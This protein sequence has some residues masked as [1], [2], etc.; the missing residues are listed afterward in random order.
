MQS[1]LD[2]LLRQVAAKAALS[3]DL[4]P[5]RQLLGMAEAPINGRPYGRRLLDAGQRGEVLLMSW[6]PGVRCAPHDH[7][8]AH[9]AMFVLRGSLVERDYDYHGELRLRGQRDLA[10]G[11]VFRL[12]EGRI[13]DMVG[14]DGAVTLH[15]YVPRIERM[16]IF[17]TQRRR[18]LTVG[19]D[20][21]AWLPGDDRG[22]VDVQSWPSAR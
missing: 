13:H 9:G 7:D 6:N 3:C 22:I 2:P 4:L 21:G 12:P 20:I 19:E 11:T 18:T 5:R 17:D 16:R 14:Y 10:E 1:F 15:V 8:G